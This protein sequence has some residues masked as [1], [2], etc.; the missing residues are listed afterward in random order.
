MPLCARR[1]LANSA[2]PLSGHWGRG[3][4]HDVAA[5]AD[6]PVRVVY[7][8]LHP[9]HRPRETSRRRPCRPTDQAPSRRRE[10]GSSFGAPNHQP[11]DAFSLSP[12]LLG[13]NSGRREPPWCRERRLSRVIS[14]TN[15]ATTIPRKIQ[16]ATVSPY[17]QYLSPGPI[18]DL[19]FEP[20]PA[21][22]LSA[23]AETAPPPRDRFRK[24]PHMPLSGRTHMPMSGKRRWR[25]VG[26]KPLLD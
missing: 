15:T 22:R 10:S 19:I 12:R 8:R 11:S 7:P 14:T 13:P 17:G 1:S 6:T 3:R 24:C 2:V 16:W 18:R 25:G 9:P 4:P 5:S 21:Q 20:T 26:T 23:V